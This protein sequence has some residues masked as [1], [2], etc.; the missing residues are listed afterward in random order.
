P[1]TR[2]SGTGDPSSARAKSRRG[3]HLA[4]ALG[5]VAATLGLLW[6]L[7]KRQTARTAPVSSATVAPAPPRAAVIS[8]ES[9]PA[10]ARVTE[11]GRELGV[12]PLKL[13]VPNAD[14]E[15]PRTFVLTLAGYRAHVFERAPGPEATYVHVDLVREAPVEA[16]PPISTPSA[17]PAQRPVAGPPSPRV[18][19]P[20]PA[21]QPSKPESAPDI[22]LVR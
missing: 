5:G 8:I 21:A 4:V 18:R 7:G 9:N 17:P 20:R 13:S 16:A 3:V 1:Q 19:A 10:G 15:R 12:T 6:Q 11:Q 2:R 22:R 14:F